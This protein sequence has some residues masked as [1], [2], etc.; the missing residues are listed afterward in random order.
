[1][2]RLTLSVVDIMQKVSVPTS[3]RKAHHYNV[4]SKTAVSLASPVS[5]FS[6]VQ[7]V[8]LLWFLATGQGLVFQCTAEQVGSGSCS[9]D[10]Q[11]RNNIVDPV[12]QMNKI[13][14]V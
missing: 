2:G 8:M 3:K 9:A 4:I 7:S 6:P 12:V 1:M 14:T 13:G 5:C 11:D 10:E